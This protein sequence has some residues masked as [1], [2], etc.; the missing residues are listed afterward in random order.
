M[1]ILII[2]NHYLEEGGEDQVVSSEIKMLKDFGHKVLFYER[3]NK[4]LDFFTT[5]KKIKFLTKDI[6]WS[7]AVYGEIKELIKKERPDIAHIHNIFILLTPSV[8]DALSD[9]DI[10]IVQTLH[11]YRL[12]CA[13]GLFYRD[14]KICEECI[15][16][17]FTPS[18]IHHCWR[19]SFILTSFI[20]KML[21]AHFKKGTFKQKIDAYIALSEFSKNKFIEAGLLREKIFIKPNFTE[22]YAAERDGFDNY[23]LFAGRLANYKGLNTLISAYQRLGAGYNLKV[24][25]DGPLLNGLKQNSERMKNVQLLGRLPT[26]TVIEYIK[27]SSFLIFPSECYENMPRVILE[28]FACG[29]PVLASNIGAIKEL[30]KD[31]ITGLLFKA[32]DIEDLATKIKELIDNKELLIQM[33]RNARRDYEEN[34]TVEKNYKILMDIYTTT[35][36]NHRKLIK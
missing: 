19:N 36:D 21:D 13:N 27:K 12:V 22:V 10:P 15:D 11:N 20:K 17:N 18:I 16:G 33:G 6:V 28:S 30:I 3:S 5:F 1:K 24:I 9:E 2:H 14:N 35:M 34:Y 26:D 29:V 8:Y 23:A 25:G 7:K 4:E 31:R 32:G